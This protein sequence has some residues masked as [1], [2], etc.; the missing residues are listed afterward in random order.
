MKRESGR[1]GVT[2][3]RAGLATWCAAVACALLT[4]PAAMAALEL[5]VAPGGDEGNTG[6]RARPF[7]TLERARD[8]VR[9]LTPGRRAQLGGVTIWLRGGT[10]HLA[11]TFELDERDSGAPGAPIVY[12]AYPGEA[13]ALSGGREIAPAAFR[14]VTDTAILERLPAE[15]RSHVLRVDL[16][17][18]GITDFGKM[19]PRG[20]GH[21][22]ANP[23]LE[24]FVNDQPM[25]L[26]RWPNR[27]TVPIG[28]IVDAGS[29]PREGDFSDRG[30]TFTYDH[31]RPAR[32]RQADDLWLSGLFAY[33]FAD[34]TLKVKSIDTAAQT[35]TL[36]Q[37]H[38]YG[39]KTDRPFHAYY[40]LNLLEEIDEPGEWYLDRGTG[41]LYLWPPAP[42]R[43][44]KVSVSL[45]E[46]PMVA[47]EGAFH[48]TFRGLTFEVTRGLGVYIERGTGDLIAACNLRNIGTTAVCIGQG[49]KA[50]PT[51][52]AGWKLDLQAEQ[53]IAGHVQPVSRELGDYAH[54]LYGDTTW[55]RNAGTNHG[56][57]GCDIYNTGAGGVSLGGGDRKTLTP[58]GNFV[59]NCHIHHFNR[60]DLSYRGA[61][62]IDG[63]GNRIAHCLIHDAPQGAIL[64]H[65]NGHVVE[66]NEIHRAC[67]LADDMGV[68]YMGRDPSERGNILRGNFFHDNG[69][70]KGA[71]CCVYLDDGS[72]GTSVIGNVFYRNRGLS[73]WINGG[74]DHLFGGN[75]FV[76]SGAAIGSGW[77]NAQWMG[78]LR[79]PLQV[80]RLRKALDVTALPYVSHYPRLASTFDEGPG[81]T[82]GNAV[83]SNVSFRSG[84]FGVGANVVRDNLVTDDDPGFADAE[85][86]D[87]RVKPGLTA[88]AGVRGFRPIDFEHIGLYRDQ[89]RAVATTREVPLVR[90]RRV[91]DPRLRQMT[92]NFAGMQPNEELPGQG[93]W[94][95]IGPGTYVA[96]SRGAKMG[97]LDPGTVAVA[98]GDDSWAALQHGMVLDPAREIVLQMAARL[99]DPLLPN[100]FFELYLDQGQRHTDAAFGVSLQGGA[101]E[102]GRTDAVGTRQDSAGPRALCTERLMPGHWY[103]VRLVIPANSLAG[104]ILLRDLSAGEAELRPLTFAQG[105]VEAKL[106]R[107]DKWA[108]A[109]GDLDTLVLRLGGG[110]Q[111]A[112]ILLRNGER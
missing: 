2:Q 40:A 93:A 12:R 77:D 53:G 43:D 108:P 16:K 62:N 109:W 102:P 110:A 94:G 3:L 10:Y 38:V 88:F 82:R 72:C 66:S 63:V 95:P 105:G 4:G 86:M 13:V 69:G 34:D 100:S 35:I 37:A 44:A 17:A 45:L 112:N 46:G 30:G 89:Y 22:Y 28:R 57:V 99:P 5:Y 41:V 36:A 56:V 91:R 58:A 71:T 18:L 78:Y 49:V 11:K 19:R 97:D 92:A 48:V 103:R 61:V 74:H 33:G 15:A 7:G 47:L 67:L 60:L 76:E 64:L 24:L 85:R 106:A 54:G 81:V 26:A 111:A 8:A 31:D 27:G 104:R 51:G 25:Q 29:V 96:V 84:D 55:N 42:L 59:L 6:T 98:V 107:G 52:L 75:A 101:E 68:F 23:G 1:R 73:I 14:P 50:D 70:S 20:F 90:P 9:A 87:L 65:G 32:W 21:P 39:L 79:D 80:L 83:L